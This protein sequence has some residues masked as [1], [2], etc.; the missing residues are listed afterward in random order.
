MRYDIIN[1][2]LLS[3]L[4]GRLLLTPVS[5][6]KRV[7]LSIYSNLLL[8]TTSRLDNLSSNSVYLSITDSS[9]HNIAATDS[10]SLNHILNARGISKAKFIVYVST[11]DFKVLEKYERYNKIK[12]LNSQSLTIDGMVRV[13]QSIVLIGYHKILERLNIT[14]LQLVDIVS[15]YTSPADDVYALLNA[16]GVGLYQDYLN[17]PLP[18]C[19][20]SVS[21]PTYISKDERNTLII[22]MYLNGLGLRQLEN[23]GFGI[24]KAAIRSILIKAGVYKGAVEGRLRH[25]SGEWHEGSFPRFDSTAN[26]FDKIARS[27]LNTWKKQ[28]KKLFELRSNASFTQQ[29][30]ANLLGCSKAYY[31]NVENGR[32]TPSQVFLSKIIK[33]FDLE[34]DSINEIAKVSTLRHKQDSKT[35]TYEDKTD[36]YDGYDEHYFKSANVNTG[37][38]S[39]I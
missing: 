33:L 37:Y 10:Q 12:P 3:L 19:L 25:Q 22:L 35:D 24:K 6:N 38:Q 20:P 26:K 39:P 30:I 15:G 18:E 2:I 34:P 5:E 21:R 13:Q 8:S 31:C 17:S 11:E 28:R 1:L 36:Y 14:I 27:K 23:S 32:E 16:C 4:W 7:D 9:N 29:Q